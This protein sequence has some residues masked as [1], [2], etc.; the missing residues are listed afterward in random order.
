MS[1]IWSLLLT[2]LWFIG[3]CLHLCA[4]LVVVSSSL[5]NVGKSWG[6]VTVTVTELESNMSF[7]S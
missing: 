7:A 6:R 3:S 2:R 5:Y 1:P 4:N